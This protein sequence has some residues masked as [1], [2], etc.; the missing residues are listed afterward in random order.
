MELTSSAVAAGMW[1]ILSRHKSRRDEMA[2]DFEALRMEMEYLSRFDPNKDGPCRNSRTEK[3]ANPTELSNV[4]RFRIRLLQCCRT[5]ASSI[6]DS[7]SRS[8][9]SSSI[10]TASQ[11][12][13]M[14][15]GGSAATIK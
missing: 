11:S 12:S 3:W 6:R 5:V 7:S 1:E 14:V 15:R 8:S 10:D 9:V 2:K 4:V 13:W